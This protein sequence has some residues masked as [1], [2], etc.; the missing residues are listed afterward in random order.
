M[1]FDKVAEWPVHK[2]LFK[3]IV[4]VIQV[5]YI[6]HCNLIDTDI[7]KAGALY[8]TVWDGMAQASES[9]T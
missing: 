2:S 1:F 5:E 3:L 4:N 6:L 7:V 9:N 8:R